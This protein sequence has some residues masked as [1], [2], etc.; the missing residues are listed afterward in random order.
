[1]R[2][3][4][5]KIFYFLICFVATLFVTACLPGESDV[6][7]RYNNINQRAAVEN[8]GLTLVHAA[9]NHTTY[10]MGL[11]TVRKSPLADEA[12]T[13]LP[14]I[15]EEQNPEPKL[16]VGL[17]VEDC[18]TFGSIAYFT[19]QP[20]GLPPL[21]II[22]GTM[23]RALASRFGA[24]SVGVKTMSGSLDM[25]KVTKTMTGSCGIIGT[26]LPGSPIFAAGFQYKETS[27]PDRKKVTW[28]GV[29]R[30]VTLPC[31]SGYN[32]VI[33][34]EQKCTFVFDENNKDLEKGTIK[35]GGYDTVNPKARQDK[36]WRCDSAD[37]PATAAEIM[38]FCRDP[39]DN[40]DKP[41]DSPVSLQAENMRILLEESRT[42]YYDF[43][44]R[45]NPDGTDTCNAT[46]V[47][48]PDVPKDT[49]YRCEKVSPT[50]LYV[51]NP[52]KP[53]TFDAS[54]DVVG[55]GP[56]PQDCG[57][58]WTGD[59][60]A[61]YQVRRCNLYRSTGSGEELV[62]RSQTLYHI[63]YAA[64]QCTTTFSMRVQCP[65]GDLTGTVP[66]V[67][68]ITMLKPAALDWSPRIPG[69]VDWSTSQMATSDSRAEVKTDAA[70]KGFVVPAISRADLSSSP[71][72]TA[73]SLKL[74]DAMKAADPSSIENKVIA[75]DDTGEPCGSEPANNEIVIYYDNGNNRPLENTP[76]DSFSFDKLICTNGTD[77]C[78]PLLGEEQPLCDGV[79]ATDGT[80]ITVSG[81]DFKELLIDFIGKI[82]S[83]N[84]PPGTSIS[85]QEKSTTLSYF[86]E[87]SD[88]CEL[89]GS[90]AK[91]MML[92]AS[93]NGNY[94]N[95]FA[96]VVCQFL[97]TDKRYNSML[98]MS[99]DAVQK[100]KESGDL[101]L[102]SLI[103]NP[104]GSG[105]GGISGDG[106][107]SAN[108]LKRDGAITQKIRLWLKNQLPTTPLRPCDSIR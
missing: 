81:G 14:T 25:P 42:G 98:Q 6:A 22:S 84:L 69:T 53:L 57:R 58:G 18:G 65:I 99:S 31:P 72:N 10:L 101:A 11:A 76:G 26:I 19:A 5:D 55:G 61:R 20:R 16:P 30:D 39:N 87:I 51:V 66:I 3:F 52:K 13:T 32:G 93:Y 23:L 82:A 37:G 49:F 100:Y 33:K 73:W 85:L 80:T 46:P 97:G 29:D 86:N 67:R 89:A 95:L 44:C 2:P 96:N 75:C 48:N 71:D 34:R 7:E 45:R 21:K 106:T 50:P 47:T 107:I 4:T 43:K 78:N 38:V 35:V 36:Q 60:T 1:M 94:D 15:S 27:L 12:L 79:C 91:R 54:G 103:T 56:S 59:L 88:V 70:T 24:E 62:Q 74:A 64:A 8:A 17:A 77:T 68:T 105:T 63:A 40:M 92:L 108:L 104:P 41:D 102:Y 9:Q 90:T 28:P 83:K